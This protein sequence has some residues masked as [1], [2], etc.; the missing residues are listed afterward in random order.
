MIDLHNDD[1]LEILAKI[2]QEENLPD[3]VK[4]ADVSL[5]AKQS[6]LPKE[7]FA[8]ESKKLC[9]MFDKA[10]TWLSSRYFI[11][12][13]QQVPPPTR[14]AVEGKLKKAYSVFGIE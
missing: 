9:P 14:T 3:F 5:M 4:Q 7:A 1:N 2:S 8:L 13:A 11:K 6:E 10:S 12:L